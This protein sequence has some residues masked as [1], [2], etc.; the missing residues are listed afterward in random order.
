MYSFNL[1]KRKKRNRRVAILAFIGA[2]GVSALTIVAFLGQSVG[3]F[4]VNLN[5]QGVSLT[6]CQN[7]AFETTTSHLNASGFEN[8]TGAHT[9]KW[10]LT[11][12]NYSFEKIHNE[13]TDYTIA[14]EAKGNGIRFFKYTFFI[15]NNG[16]LNASY[17]LSVTITDNSVKPQNGANDVEQYLRLM[18]FEGEGNYDGKVYAYHSLTREPNDDGSFKPEYIC[19]EPKTDSDPGEAEIF[20]DETA[21]NMELARVTNNLDPND[22]R[23]YT[24][25]FWLEGNDPECGKIPDQASLRIGATINAYPQDKEAD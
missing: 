18:V 17:D 15:L 9:Y 12:T 21:G 22:S 23:M 4:T 10:F 24:L 1:V 14:K 16:N 3:S 13:N 7:S 20:Y 8:F 25:L 2:L 6:L 5:N 19:T 11:S